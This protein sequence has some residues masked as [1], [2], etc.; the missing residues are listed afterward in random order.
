VQSAMAALVEA[1]PVARPRDIL[2]RLN[3]VLFDNIRKRLSHD[4]H[5]T[6]SLLRYSVGGYFVFAGAH[7]EMLVY[8]AATGAVE[9]I[10]T[11]G[12]WVGARK[13]IWGV[14]VDSSLR[15]EV[16]DVLLLYTDGV[17]EARD[18]DG[19]QFELERLADLLQ[20]SSREPAAVIVGNVV[21][22]VRA[23]MKEQADDISVMVVRYDGRT[24]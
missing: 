14:T 4:D 5:V 24:G 15:L 3:E 13:D 9:S 18:A 17:T 10:E 6:L 19:R 23:W 1:D 21:A 20:R 16:G 22:A 2:C 12:T 8:R 7:E 11:P